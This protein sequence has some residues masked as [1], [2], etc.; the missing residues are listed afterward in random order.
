LNQALEA[1]ASQL[2]DRL[3]FR[4]TKFQDKNL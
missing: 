3:K 2:K 1:E 4:T